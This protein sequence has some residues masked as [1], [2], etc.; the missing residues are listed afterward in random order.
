MAK[1][2]DVERLLSHVPED[3][4]SVGNIWLRGE[5]GWTPEKYSRVRQRLIE[6]GDLEVGRGQGGSVYRTSATRI[7]PPSKQLPS[8]PGSLI[9]I[10]HLATLSK[11]IDAAIQGAPEYGEFDFRNLVC[12]TIGAIHQIPRL[13]YE[14]NHKKY[15]LKQVDA[16][17]GR[18]SCGS[19]SVAANINQRLRAGREQRGHEYGMIFA[20]SSIEASLRY[21]RHGIHLLQ[22]LEE[23]DGL[24]ISNKSFSAVGGVGST[25]PG[26]LYMTFKML[27]YESEPGHELTDDEIKGLVLDYRR[28][29][30][31]NIEGKAALEAFKAGL[32]KANEVEFKGEKRP[33]LIEYNDD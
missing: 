4:S 5:L 20:R 15:Q 30:E 2:S 33:K 7:R 11:D 14:K 3:G 26:F 31:N 12:N 28:E 10:F 1:T 29:I 27:E 21:E 16:Y 8:N 13:F 9:P 32:E 22:V 23:M 17:F 24:C 18:S 25:G 19:Q 6:N